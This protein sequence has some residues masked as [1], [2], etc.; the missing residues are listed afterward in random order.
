MP[1]LS[2]GGPFNSNL[3]FQALKAK[4]IG[5]KSL[6][7]MCLM[8]S[9]MAAELAAWLNVFI[10]LIYQDSLVVSCKAKKK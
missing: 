9:I 4:F 6:Q 10:H 3:T 7:L 8:Y 5:K 2:C 1:D